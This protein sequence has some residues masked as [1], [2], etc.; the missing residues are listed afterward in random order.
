MK[1]YP[2][3]NSHAALVCQVLW[4]PKLELSSLRAAA[5]RVTLLNC[6]IP[7]RKTPVLCCSYPFSR[8]P[9]PAC[10]LCFC[11][12]RPAP[13]L[14]CPTVTLFIHWAV[15]CFTSSMVEDAA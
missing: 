1:R 13:I 6:C 9:V 5:S 15:Y 11:Q 7:E 12:S 8:S 10:V 14:P 4:L 2:S 3:T